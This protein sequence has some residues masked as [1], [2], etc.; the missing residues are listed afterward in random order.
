MSKQLELFPEEE[1]KMKDSSNENELKPILDAEWCFQFFDNEPIVF[2]WN[3][4]GVE[5][6]PMVIN[7][8]S[9][10]GEGVTFQQNGM[11][12]KIFPRPISEQTKEKR[13]LEI[14]KEKNASKD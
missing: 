2:A 4:E 1:S 10:E 8:N 13:N 6:A 11:F 12:F 7:V 5:A 3:K 9:V 14:Q